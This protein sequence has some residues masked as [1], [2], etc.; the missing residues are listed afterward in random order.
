MT[1]NKGLGVFCLVISPLARHLVPNPQ[2]K[3]KKYVET[4]FRILDLIDDLRVDAL[5]RSAT[6]DRQ[7]I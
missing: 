6:A 5:D 3:K 1:K 2:K 7:Y 4:E